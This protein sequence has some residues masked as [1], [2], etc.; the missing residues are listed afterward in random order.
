MQAENELNLI[1]QLAV[2]GQF[3]DRVGETTEQLQRWLK[4]HNL[5][6][7]HGEKRLDRA[8]ARLHDERLTVAF[9]AEFSRGKSELINAI[10]FSDFPDRVLPSSAGRTTMCP[11]EL[12]AP[13]LGGMPQISLLPIETATLGSVAELRLNAEHWMVKPITESNLRSLQD[14]FSRVR[15]T[16]RVSEEECRKLG[17]SIDANGQKGLQPGSDGMVE[18]PRWRHAIIEFDHALLS[19]GLVILDTPGLNAIGAEPELTFSLLPSADAVLFILAADTGV[20][21][22]DLAIW[23]DYVRPRSMMDSKRGQF[24]VLNK[25]DSLWDGLRDDADIDYEIHQQAETV[26]GMLGL[27][28][29]Q[30]FPLSAQ[31]ALVGR[32]QHQPE[33]VRKSRIETFERALAHDML[34]TKKQIVAENLHATASEIINRAHETLL[35]E[36]ANLKTQLGELEG[37]RGKNHTVIEYMMGK[38]V[39]EKNRFD[40]GLKKYYAVR[41]VFSAQSS[42]LLASLD[43]TTL[44]KESQRVRQQMFKS[45][46]SRGLRKSME[47]F[48]AWLHAALAQAQR[49][50]GEITSMLD[51]TYKRFATEH[52]LKLAP[53]VGFSLRRFEREIRRLREVYERKVSGSF[54]LVGLEQRVLTQKFFDTVAT[55]A[56]NTFDIA[57]HEAEQWLNSAIT[58]LETQIREHQLQLKRR[59]DGVKRISETT[60][61]L[62]PRLCELETLRE[63]VQHRLLHLSEHAERVYQALGLEAPNA[64]SAQDAQSNQSDPAPQSDPANTPL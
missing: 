12:R 43:A 29:S 17:F 34:P 55:Q 1:D 27:P 9:V 31:K 28:A 37:L 50:A 23:R 35:L 16:T 36:Q 62:E 15:E 18:V 10:F 21:Q 58:P 7:E 13:R 48:F 57:G 30:I 39:E 47:G 38:I 32:I 64:Q 24:V 11:T 49:D 56:R 53:P 4:D 40:N 6:D 3:R 26:G 52:N 63:S 25:I 19:Q 51:A 8:L 44:H 54:F 22:S 42:K 2:Y 41:S 14:A 33:L 5:L 61:A 45:I 59:L 60:D 46:F 20:T